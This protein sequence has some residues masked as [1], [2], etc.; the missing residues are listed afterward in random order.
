[1]LMPATV[2]VTAYLRI[3]PSAI[4]NMEDPMYMGALGY[5][6][7]RSCWLADEA[8]PGRLRR[9]IRCSQARSR[10]APPAGERN[11]V[12]LVHGLSGGLGSG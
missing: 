6:C 12:T 9:L 3:A 8:R 2:A 5:P 4:M 11:E 10:P 1:M 7:K